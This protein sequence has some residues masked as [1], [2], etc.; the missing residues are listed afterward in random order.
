MTNLP[1]TREELDA[2]QNLWELKSPNGIFTT[3]EFTE[4]LFEQGRIA[5]KLA[6][7]LEN[8]LLEIYIPEPNCACHINPPCSDCEKNGGLREFVKD[9]KKLLE[10][11]YSK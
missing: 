7:V 5:H 4:K 2:G 1:L 9:A 3:Y 11:D 8:L 6:E 10:T